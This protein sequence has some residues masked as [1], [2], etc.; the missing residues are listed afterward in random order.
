MNRIGQKPNLPCLASRLHSCCL[1]SVLS[2]TLCCVPRQSGLEEVYED[3]HC[4]P[5]PLGD[6]AKQLDASLVE[7]A[8]RTDIFVQQV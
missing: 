3:P 1:T 5:M 6:L 8:M 7:N 2:E 4:L